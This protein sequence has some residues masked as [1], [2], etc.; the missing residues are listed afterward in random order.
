MRLLYRN[1]A[2]PMRKLHRGGVFGF[3]YLQER[4]VLCDR[5]Y[6]VSGNDVI[7]HK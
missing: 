1:H 7:I 4:K 2:A 5:R 6:S 3:E